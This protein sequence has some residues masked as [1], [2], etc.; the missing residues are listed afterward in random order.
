MGCCTG[1]AS[2]IPIPGGPTQDTSRSAGK[3]TIAIRYVGPSFGSLRWVGPSGKSYSFGGESP[4][5][6]VQS[7]D[8]DWFLSLPDFVKVDAWDH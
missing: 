5:S 8:V 7:E 1:T 2:T 3:G 4:V 6:T